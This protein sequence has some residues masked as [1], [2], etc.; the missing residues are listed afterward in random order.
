MYKELVSLQERAV[1]IQTSQA[2]QEEIFRIH[3]DARAN[4]RGELQ[5]L[6]MN[7]SSDFSREELEGMIAEHHEKAEAAKSTLN[8]LNAEAL[9][10]SPAYKQKAESFN[11]ECTS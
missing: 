4:A 8:A 6:S 5:N 3:D 1:A 11:T 7:I 9:E 2:E 10:V